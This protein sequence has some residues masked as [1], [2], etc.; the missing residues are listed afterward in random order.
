MKGA[1]LAAV[2]IILLSTNLSEVNGNE[3]TITLGHTDSQPL[4]LFDLFRFPVKQVRSCTPRSSILKAS[5]N[6][7]DKNLLADIGH[8]EGFDPDDVVRIRQ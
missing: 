4:N 7:I 3:V 8:P 6:S 1:F 2:P 5:F